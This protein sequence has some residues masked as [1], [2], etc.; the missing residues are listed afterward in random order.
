MATVLLFFIHLPGI[1]LFQGEFTDGVLQTVYFQDPIYVVG[2]GV[3][4]AKYV[5]PLFPALISML[6]NFGLEP[7]VAG[8]LISLVYYC[9][10]A[11]VLGHLG[12]WLGNKSKG[13]HSPQLLGWAAWAFW[14]LSPVANRWALHSMS[15]MTFCFFFS[16]SLLFFLKFSSEGKPGEIRPWALGNLAALCAVWTRY[17]GYA[18]AGA[19][20]LSMGIV[21]YRASRFPKEGER[22]GLERCL[23]HKYILV[24][25]LLIAA[26]AQ[27]YTLQKQGRTIHEG[28][29]SERAVYDASIYL[30]FALTGLRYLPY[31]VTP[32]LFVLFLVGIGGALRKGGLWSI[33]TGI[34]LLGGLAGLAVQTWFLSFQFRY[35]LPFLPWVCLVGGLGL[36]ILPKKFLI[37]SV[38][39]AL[40]WLGGFTGAVLYFQHGTFADIE[41]TARDIPDRLE[42]GD[43]VWAREEY[44]F[45]P[46]GKV[47]YGNVKVSVWSG[48]PVRWLDEESLTELQEGDLI[49]DPNVTPIPAE[50]WRRIR[51]RWKTEAIIEKVSRSVPLTPGEILW[52]DYPTPQGPRV[53]RGTSDPN[54]MRF[55][56]KTQYYSTTVY[57][58]HSPKTEPELP[59][60]SPPE[61]STLKK[62]KNDSEPE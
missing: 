34:G 35:G 18:L 44:N 38:A 49:V 37:P 7:L 2:E 9:G 31:A 56:Y 16:L 25:L 29:F 48:V 33:W 43:R 40:T 30:N 51:T 8:R 10:V 60:T 24:C 3:P 17:Q 20:L 61:G 62:S 13:P 59:I 54:L 27:T 55:R 41:A 39:I 46:D 6:A 47:K 42:E 45:L 4:P 58:L 11:I 52:V 14:A 23:N 32:P 36:A 1:S 53:I 19:A 5:P 50:F 28:Q 21:F 57:R 26:W 12:I 15:D 22:T